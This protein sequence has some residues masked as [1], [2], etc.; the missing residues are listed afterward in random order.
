MNIKFQNSLNRVPQKCPPIWFMR[1]AGRYHQHY[2]NLRAQH[3]FMELCVNPDLATE[4][5]MG[6]IEDFDFDVAILFSD[7]LFPLQALGMGL[8]Y[9]PGPVLDWHLTSEEDLKKL[10]DPIKSVAQL[11]FQQE[12]LLKIRKVL[13]ESKS[14]IGFV[15]G[16]WTLFSYAVEG[17]HQGGLIQT[18]KNLSLY[19]KF[20]QILMPLLLENIQLQIDGGAEMVMIFDTAAGDLDPQTFK[21]V[22]LPELEQLIQKFPNRLAYYAKNTQPCYLQGTSLLKDPWAGLGFDHKW[23]LT[24]CFKLRNSGFVQGNFD[25]HLLFQKSNDFQNS[26]KKYLEPFQAMSPEAR[27]GWVCGLGHGVLPAT[28]E[29]NVRDFVKIV[30]ESF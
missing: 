12:A 24:E 4:V 28:P 6:P 17:S 13:P 18:K 15:G 29:Q 19:P 5:T 27:A 11:M 9:E 21:D 20:C 22:V 26:L 25:Q 14:L 10:A 1:Q 8:R 3:G 16:P 30:R 23:N 7:L 2:Q